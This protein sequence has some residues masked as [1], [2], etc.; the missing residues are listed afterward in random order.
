MELLSPFILLTVLELRGRG[1]VYGGGVVWGNSLLALLMMIWKYICFA[2]AL[3]FFSYRHPVV[4]PF[5]R[6]SSSVEFFQI[7][8][9]P[10][11]LLGLVSMVGVI[12]RVI[13]AELVKKRESE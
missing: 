5:A 1:C 3:C 12:D 7:H 9:C 11:D 4:S 6:V 8:C 2:R 13:D 10:Y